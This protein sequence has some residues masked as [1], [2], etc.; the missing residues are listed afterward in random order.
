MKQHVQILGW[1]HII[2]GV[3]GILLAVL[4]GVFLVGIGM[5]SGDTTANNILLVIAIITGGFLALVSVPGV[6]AGIGLL[7]TRRWAR[8]LAIILGILNLP[9]FPIGTLLGAYTLYVMLDD[10][11]STLF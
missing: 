5:I 9:G 2:L 4:L 11:T 8:V 7:G 6:V 3:L 10:E 1:T